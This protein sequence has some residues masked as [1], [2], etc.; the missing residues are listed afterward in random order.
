MNNK[1]KFLE[2]TADI[3]FIAKGKNLEES[4]KN[5]ALAVS[6]SM[7]KEE[8]KKKIIKRIKITGKDKESL[9]YNFLDQIIY[10]FDAEY[11]LISDVKSIKINKKDQFYLSCELVGD[12]SEKYEI[13]EHIKSV[14][15]SEMK[16]ERKHDAYI[17]QV[18]LDI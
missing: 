15:Y 14:T 11:F 1:F 18:V 9:L 12:K 4:F 10:L 2:H 13:A 6:N 5:S 16:I 8:I 17:I 3:K 7:C